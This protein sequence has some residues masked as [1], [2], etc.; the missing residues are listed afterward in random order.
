[1]PR[2]EVVG[3][4]RGARGAVAFPGEELRGRPPAGPRG[5]QTDELTDRLEVFLN[6]VE[7]L[8][9]L[10]VGGPAVP[11]A[12]RVDENQVGQVEQRPLVA[13]GSGGGGEWLP[14]AGDRP[15]GGAEG[16]HVQPDGRRAGPA[17]EA[18]CDRPLRRVLTSPG[19]G[20]V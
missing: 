9:I 3:Q 17:V 7:L 14:V 6:T 1:E 11:G 18:E 8:G 10:L 2:L 12:D 13:Q 5:V 4:A 19:V 20:D 16:A 15:W